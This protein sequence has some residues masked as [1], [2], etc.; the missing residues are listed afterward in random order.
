MKIVYDE[1]KEKISKVL[2]QCEILKIGF[3]DRFCF[4]ICREYSVFFYFVLFP[5]ILLFFCRFFS[6]KSFEYLLFEGRM[7]LFLLICS[8]LF[9]FLLFC[10]QN[11]FVFVFRKKSGEFCEGKHKNS[12]FVFGKNGYILPF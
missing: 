12:N 2:I 8:I 1:M 9:D 11:V 3:S 5:S 4:R 7:F 10:S 6:S